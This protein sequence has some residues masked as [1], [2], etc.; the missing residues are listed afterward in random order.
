MA[1]AVHEAH[2]PE[3]LRF[4]AADWALGAGRVSCGGRSLRALVECGVC[5]ADLD[6]DSPAQLFAVGAGPHAGDAGDGARLAVVDVALGANVHLGLPR[7][8]RLLR[9][10]R[11]NEFLLGQEIRLPLAPH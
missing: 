3:E 2:R 6:R 4:L 8:Q 5:V 10:R 7:K 9:R 11:G 1:G